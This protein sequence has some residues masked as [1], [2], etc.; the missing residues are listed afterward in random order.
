[1]LIRC[2]S[3]CAQAA[4]AQVGSSISVETSSGVTSTWQVVLR[5]IVTI[6]ASACR[7]WQCGLTSS[8]VWSRF[9]RL[10][11]HRAPSGAC[12]RVPQRYSWRCTAKHAWRYIMQGKVV[13]IRGGGYVPPRQGDLVRL[14]VGLARVS[15][16]GGFRN[17]REV[18]S[19][20]RRND[21]HSARDLACASPSD[22]WSTVK[23]GKAAFSKGRG[24][25]ISLEFSD[26]G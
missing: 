4:L 24:F 23:G 8:N 9:A 17:H 11:G 7:C 19:F 22:V 16:V 1:M 20:L 6:V 25:W 26:S 13:E 15:F 12:I 21:P 14:D 10:L 5:D 3:T 2:T 18:R